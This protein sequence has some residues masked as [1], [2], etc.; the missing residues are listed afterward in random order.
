M[1]KIRSAALMAGPMLVAHSALAKKPAGLPGN[2]LNKPVR[3]IIGASAGGGTDILGRLVYRFVGEA[4]KSSFIVENKVSVMGSALALDEVAKAP[5]DGY[6][7][8]VV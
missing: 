1:Q 8:N 3:V 5:P 6:M 2:Y 4:W 7:L